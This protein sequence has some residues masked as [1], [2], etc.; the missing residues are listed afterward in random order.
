MDRK[1]I[2]K[3]EFCDSYICTQPEKLAKHIRKNHRPTLSCKIC[4][5][6]CL[7]PKTLRKHWKTHRGGQGSNTEPPNTYAEPIFICEL[8]DYQCTAHSILLGHMKQHKEMLNADKPKGFHHDGSRPV[9]YCDS[10]KYECINPKTMRKHIKNHKKGHSK[11]APSNA[12]LHL[13]HVNPKSSQ[14]CVMKHTDGSE[15]DDNSVSAESFDFMCPTPYHKADMMDFEEQEHRTQPFP[16]KV[17][18]ERPNQPS[19][20]MTCSGTGVVLR[21]NK[22]Y[23]A[24]YWSQGSCSS[25]TGH[26]VELHVGNNVVTSGDVP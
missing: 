11:A 25:N 7:N 23:C 21:D 2:L 14:I 3:C 26:L 6:K 20:T 16:A 5:Y 17:E 12:Q 13:Q 10:C 15:V 19:K 9:L 4:N 24:F 8:C 22:P 18:I 1:A